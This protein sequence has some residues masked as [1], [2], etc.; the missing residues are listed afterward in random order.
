MV[1]AAKVEGIDYISPFWSTQFFGY[2]DYT[3]S[4]AALSYQDLATALSRVA[5]Q[6][7][8]NNQFSSTGTFYG[9]LAGNALTTT[10]AAVS[11]PAATT[12][13]L[14]GKPSGLLLIAGLVA[15]VA[16]VAAVVLSRRR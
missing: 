1:T 7:I 14:T 8:L 12:V 4:T 10:T 16:I 11:Q 3:S 6:N 15:A 2:V 5:S 13:S 9:Q